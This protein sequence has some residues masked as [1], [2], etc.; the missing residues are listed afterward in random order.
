MQDEKKKGEI[1]LE[2]LSQSLYDA[3][4][5]GAT[6]LTAEE[7]LRI[8][9][10]TVDGMQYLHGER[11]K[12]VHRD[13]KPHNI[14]L[15]DA[16]KA[17]IIDFGLA[18]T[19]SSSQMYKSKLNAAGTLVYMAPEF[20]VD[21]SG[22]NHKVDVYSFAI[23]MWEMYAKQQPFAAASRSE[24]ALKR[25]VPNGVRPTPFEGSELFP[26]TVQD[27]IQGCWQTDPKARPEFSQVSMRLSAQ[28][29]G[30]SEVLKR[31]RKRLTL[32]LKDDTFSTNIT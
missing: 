25:D 8:F 10:G 11:P 2:L 30:K 22:G 24:A 31:Y 4:Y 28:R 7:M 32:Y 17:K 3:I 19:K 29:E 6:P 16:M 9:T 5:N 1:V 15:T 13:L 27:V 21:E 18:V 12:V 23:T 20:L 14:C 26:P